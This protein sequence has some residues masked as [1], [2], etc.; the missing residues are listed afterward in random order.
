VPVSRSVIRTTSLVPLCLLVV[1]LLGNAYAVSVQPSVSP[2][3]TSSPTNYLTYT[4]SFTYMMGFDQRE[5]KQQLLN[6]ERMEIMDSTADTIRRVLYQRSIFFSGANVG[7]RKAVEEEE[8]DYPGGFSRRYLRQRIKKEQGNDRKHIAIENISD[9]QD[10][11]IVDFHVQE[12]LSRD[13][14]VVLSADGGI[15]HKAKIDRACT[16]DFEESTDCILINSEVTMQSSSRIP[17]SAVQ[18]SIIY[19]VQSSMDEDVFETL[20]G[21]DDVKEVVFMYLGEPQPDNDI[22]AGGGP[23]VGIT[24]A[25]I[26]IGSVLFLAL[27]AFFVVRISECSI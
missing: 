3:V 9:S 7:A 16:D 25:G 17:L 6:D 23:I 26:V 10:H 20:M 21:K 15:Y 11:M 27:L 13:L 2:T 22:G 18:N 24:I 4:V 1:S 5:V 14:Q 12:V 19:S 8:E